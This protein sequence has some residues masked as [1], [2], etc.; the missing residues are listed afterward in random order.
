MFLTSSAN[1]LAKETAVSTLGCPF[2]DLGLTWDLFKSAFAPALA[3][4]Q[5]A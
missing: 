4:L 2:V 3:A 1:I 5:T